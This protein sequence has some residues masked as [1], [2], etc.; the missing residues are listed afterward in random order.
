MLYVCAQVQTLQDSFKVGELKVRKHVESGEFSLIR[1]GSIRASDPVHLKYPKYVSQRSCS[2]QPK[3]SGVCVIHLCAC[4]SVW[5]PPRACCCYS[6]HPGQEQI[7]CENKRSR[8]RPTGRR[9]FRTDALGLRFSC[10]AEE[11]LQIGVLFFLF[12]DGGSQCK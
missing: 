9:L 12:L 5:A 8:F 10:A 2:T 3:W 11:C 1:P 6:C 7:P 4:C